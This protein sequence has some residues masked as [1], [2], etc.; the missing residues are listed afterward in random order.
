[1]N[2]GAAHDSIVAIMK[3]ASS[4]AAVARAVAA[5]AARSDPEIAAKLEAL[6]FDQVVAEI[7]AMAANVERAQAEENFFK[8]E[9]LAELLEFAAK[10]LRALA[11]CL[12]LIPGCEGL[13]AL[14]L[15][16]ASI[17][18]DVAKLAREIAEVWNALKA[19]AQGDIAALLQRFENL[20]S[21]MAS[22]QLRALSAVQAVRQC[23]P[24]LA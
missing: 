22:L 12:A 3:G 1:M 8:F 11:A 19:A 18:E 2:A 4:I 15:D 9:M 16:Q 23:A 24:Q 17:L 10:T 6:H 20:S 14:L 13:Q 7:E 5:A 21:A